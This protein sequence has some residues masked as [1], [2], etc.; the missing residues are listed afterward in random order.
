MVNAD[1]S[2]LQTAAT[3]QGAISAFSIALSPERRASPLD[4]ASAKMGL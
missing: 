4:P 3:K 1:P 2:V